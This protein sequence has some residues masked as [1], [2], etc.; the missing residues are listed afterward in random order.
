MDRFIIDKNSAGIVG[1]WDTYNDGEWVCLKI[2]VND[3]DKLVDKLNELNKINEENIK[4]INRIVHNFCNVGNIKPTL[5]ERL[6][7]EKVVSH[8]IS[9]LCNRDLILE[10]MDEVSE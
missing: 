6:L 9:G 1:V 5:S 4:I 8:I 3:Y 10:T 2:D 7:I